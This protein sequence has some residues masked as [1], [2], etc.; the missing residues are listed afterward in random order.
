MHKKISYIYRNPSATYFSIEHIFNGVGD[1]LKNEGI[2][3]CRHVLKFSG[4]SLKTLWLNLNSFKTKADTIYHITGDVHYMCIVTMKQSVLTI[5][6]IGSAYQRNMLKN[7]YVKLFWFWL[8][9]LVVGRITVVS[10]FTKKEL[11]KIIPFAKAKIRVVY[12]YVDPS[13]EPMPL[14]C[15]EVPKVLFIGTKSNKNLERSL[16]AIKSINCHIII[17]GCLSLEQKNLLQMLELSYNN[18]YN[19]SRDDV[20]A[21]YVACDVLCFASTYE[22]FGMPI[23]EAQALGRPVITSNSGAMKEVAAN[24]ACLIDPYDTNAIAS[25]VKQVTSNLNYR[26]L[27]IE[28]GLENVKRFSIAQIALK[29][30]NVYAELS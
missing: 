5:H 2:E 24:S 18:Y 27:L 9:A 20:K 30:K 26:D 11:T 13:F 29:Y 21:C 22:G 14:T 1:Y 16:K 7:L 10:Q 23:I 17:L 25:A 6:D 4:A 3:V 15:N 19:I 8:P 12:N 28:K